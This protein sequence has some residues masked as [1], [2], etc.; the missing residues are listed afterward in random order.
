MTADWILLALTL[1]F[2]ALLVAFYSAQSAWFLAA[3]ALASIFAVATLARW[4]ARTYAPPQAARLASV[5]TLLLGVGTGLYVLLGPT[6]MRCSTSVSAIPGQPAPTPGPLVCESTNMLQAQTVWPMPLLAFAVW[7]LAPLL[8][9]LAVWSG[10]PWLVVVAMVIEITALVTGAGLL[11]LPL[12]FVPLVMTL[13]LAR[14]AS[15]PSSA[16]TGA[17]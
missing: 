11:Y 12:V 4:L 3:L 5:L 13:W 16:V 2:A 6:G 7:S 8:A 14:R 10:R 15:G 9:V 1:F 17:S